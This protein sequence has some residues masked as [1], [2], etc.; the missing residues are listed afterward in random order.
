MD[1]RP[2]TIW[3]K[4]WG[5]YHWRVWRMVNDG[6]GHY[7]SIAKGTTVTWPLAYLMARLNGGK[8]VRETV[9]TILG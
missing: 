1:E 6:R 9:L 8:E 2:I 4:G 5:L 3:K 7:W